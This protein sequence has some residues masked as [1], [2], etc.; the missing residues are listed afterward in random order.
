MYRQGRVLYQAK[1]A[2]YW[3]HMT[4]N[5]VMYSTLSFSSTKQVDTVYL[6]DAEGCLLAIKIWDGLKVRLSV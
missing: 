2:V 5:Q 4:V 3:S 1:T 6:S